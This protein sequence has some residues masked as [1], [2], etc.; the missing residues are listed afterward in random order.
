VEGR[1]DQERDRCR[2]PEATDRGRVA[3]DRL[4]QVVEGR[5]AECTQSERRHRDPELACRQ[6]GVDV[7]DRVR[8]RLRSRPPFSEQLLRLSRP[9][10]RHRE[11]DRDEN[12]FA[13]TRTRA[14]AS[15]PAISRG[16]EKGSL[17]GGSSSTP[18]AGIVANQPQPQPP[19][20][21]D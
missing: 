18:S 20:A 14:T 11:L 10:T 13:A 1:D 9:Q 4:E 21:A 16:A 2:E 15:P 6:V 3:E 7:L 19:V 17:S 8:R 12:P 5:L